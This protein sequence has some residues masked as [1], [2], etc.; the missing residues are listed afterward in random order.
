LAVALGLLTI[1]L[2]S[3]VTD[4]VRSGQV[5]LPRL[6]GLAQ[7]LATN[8]QAWLWLL[9]LTVLV[10]IPAYAVNAGILYS[11]SRELRSQFR[12]SYPSPTPCGR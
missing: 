3:I 11:R 5:S 4:V 7:D 9:V 12:E 1:L 2:P 6:A 8:G 10:A